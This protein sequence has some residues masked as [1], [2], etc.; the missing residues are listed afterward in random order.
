MI[1]TKRMNL[2]EIDCLDREF[3][4]QQFSDEDV[5]RYLFDAE[6]VKTPEE[7]DEIIEFYV[8]AAK[9]ENGERIDLKNVVEASREKEE[10]TGD[11]GDSGVLRAQY[12][13][14]LILLDGTKI[15]TCG[16][17]CVNRET[18]SA[19]IGYDMQ[20]KFWGQG[21]MSEAVEAILR[22]AKKEL[23]LSKISAHIYPENQGSVKLAERCGFQKSDETVNYNFRGKDYLHYV[24]VKNLE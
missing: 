5:N 3:I 10:K 18:G 11:T 8:N 19:E 20:K 15:G 2:K 13:W 6:P 24:Y 12:R 16:F 21:Y 4:F 22:F 7:A 14:I 23:K 17:H 1:T 9:A